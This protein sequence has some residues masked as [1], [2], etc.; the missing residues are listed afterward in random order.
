MIED[1]PD[2]KLIASYKLIKRK[3]DHTEVFTKDDRDLQARMRELKREI[4]K[5][6]L[7]EKKN[8]KG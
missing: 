5:R 6:K 3:L 2:S 1:I 4:K 8:G 7:I